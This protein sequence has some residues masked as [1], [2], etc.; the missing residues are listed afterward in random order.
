MSPEVEHVLAE[1]GAV[2]LAC[3]ALFAAFSLVGWLLDARE[4]RRFEGE[5]AA[6][7][8][9]CAHRTVRV[10]WAVSAAGEMRDPRPECVDCGAAVEGIE[11]KVQSRAGEK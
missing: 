10:R 9:P 5:M 8:F 7:R 4:R 11:V 6:K 1:A 2:A 3:V